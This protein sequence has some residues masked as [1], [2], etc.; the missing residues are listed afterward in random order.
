MLQVVFGDSE[1]G[2]I[3]Q[4]MRFQTEGIAFGVGLLL[5]ENTVMT[6]PEKAEAQAEAEHQME[7]ELA[8]GKALEG[9]PEDA[10]ALPFPLDIGD[11]RGSVFSDARKELLQEIFTANP[12]GEEPEEPHTLDEYWDNCKQDQQR[13]L[14]RAAEGEPVRI[15]YSHVPYALCGFYSVLHMLQDMD[16]AVTAVKLPEYWE[17]PDGVVVSAGSFGEIPAGEWASFLSYE[18]KIPD[19]MRWR[20][21]AVWK[22]LQQENAPLRAVINGRLHSVEED[23]YDRFLLKAA[24]TETQSV[25][26]VIGT[27]IGRYEL[28]IGDWFLAR[29]MEKLIDSGVFKI[30]QQGNG[31]YGNLVIKV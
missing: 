18:A 4:A 6:E 3:V 8:R 24:S 21:S 15:W 13:L 26:S 23:F 27:A 12:W 16:C 7:L 22:Q 10:I 31:F 14:Q 1:K 29:R 9:N 17:R 11:I 2:T 19:V 20:F 30:E 5:D 28:C 25:G